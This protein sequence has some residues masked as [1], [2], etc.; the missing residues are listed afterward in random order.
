MTE[1]KYTKEQYDALI[2][3]QL[4]EVQHYEQLERLRKTDSG[5]KILGWAAIILMLV[6]ILLGG[7]IG[8]KEGFLAG[9]LAVAALIGYF[10]SVNFDT[11]ISQNLIVSKDKLQNLRDARDEA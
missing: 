6:T 2:E 1:T 10:K 4:K 7:M 8:G 5:R 11:T 3:E 9:S